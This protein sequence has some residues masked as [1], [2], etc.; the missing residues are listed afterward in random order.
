[1]QNLGVLAVYM[2]NVH[3]Y[4]MT[5]VKANHQA[6]LMMNSGVIGPWPELMISTLDRLAGNA[7]YCRAWGHWLPEVQCT[8]PFLS[9]VG[10]KLQPQLL[11]P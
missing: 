9:V 3:C 1:M 4:W 7:H 8:Y 10:A 5:V 2:E 6:D 11:W